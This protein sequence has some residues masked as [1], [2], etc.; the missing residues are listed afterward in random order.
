MDRIRTQVKLNDYTKFLDQI[1]IFWLLGYLQAMKAKAILRI[2]IDL[3][4][5]SL[6][7]HA[8]YGT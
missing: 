5:P 6:L 7:A 2:C 3:P 8:K 4:E 1:L